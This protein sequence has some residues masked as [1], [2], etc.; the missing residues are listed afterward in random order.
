MPWGCY[1][2]FLV[3]GVGGL[4]LLWWTLEY[5]RSNTQQWMVPLGLVLFGTP[6]VVWFSILASQTNFLQ[7][8]NQEEEENSTSSPASSCPPCTC[9]LVIVGSET[10]TVLPVENKS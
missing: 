4:L 3:C 7:V 6:I 8:Q 9:Q 10:Y 5:H 2:S 1:S